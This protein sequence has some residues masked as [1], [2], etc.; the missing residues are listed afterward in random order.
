MAQNI[1]IIQYA[2]MPP[3]GPQLALAGQTHQLPA[4]S[5]IGEIWFRRS[6]K[7]KITEHKRSMGIAVG[8]QGDTIYGAWRDTVKDQM[9]ARVIRRIFT[10]SLTQNSCKLSLAS[11]NWDLPAMNSP[12]HLQRTTHL[13][14]RRWPRQ[15]S[16]WLRTVGRSWLIQSTWKISRFRRCRESL[17]HRWSFRTYYPLLSQIVTKQGRFH[18]TSSY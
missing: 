7:R 12:L 16:N 13:V 18:M 9:L 15:W 17:R 6:D 8:L 2:L 5:L 14:C 11:G 3:G 10:T 4:N 1:N